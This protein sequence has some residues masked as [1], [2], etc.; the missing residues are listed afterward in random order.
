M[1]KGTSYQGKEKHQMGSAVSRELGIKKK[2]AK[3]MPQGAD[4][5]CGVSKL[6]LIRQKGGGTGVWNKIMERQFSWRST[7]GD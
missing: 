3:F 5:D 2:S 4:G 6:A 1:N 7:D